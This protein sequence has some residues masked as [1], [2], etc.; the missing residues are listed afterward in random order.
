MSGRWPFPELSPAVHGGVDAVELAGL[1]V[2][3]A[4]VIDFSSNQSPL[5]VA[6]AARE[7]ANE[8]ELDSYPDRDARELVAALA[9]RHEVDPEWVVAGNGSTELIRLIAQLTLLP[10]DA[11]LS[12]APSFG[13]YEMGTLLARGRFLELPLELEAPSLGD[14]SGDLP[15]LPSRGGLS[16]QGG[17]AFDRIRFEAELHRAQPRLCWVCSPNN[18]TG[19]AV[20]PDDLETLL[21]GFPATLFVLD[22]AYCDLLPY[23][24]WSR[25]TLERGNLVVL[26]SM[27]KVW[28]L[29]GLRLGYAVADPSISGPLRAA[30][31]PWNVNACAQA[32]GLAAISQ[33]ERHV[34]AVELLREGRDELAAEIAALGFSVLRSSAGFFL[35][36]VDDPAAVR[37]S[38]LRH[39][40]LVRDCTSFGLPRHIRVSPKRADENDV[41][42]AAFREVA[43]NARPHPEADR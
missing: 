13:E 2:D 27:T 3:P 24:Q 20:P 21:H 5:G 42:V 41:L 31:P 39:R 35:I 36:E 1:G 14:T 28:G 12:L 34:R 33:D 26:R 10:G 7:A 22:E 8:A 9:A 30:S 11:A 19:A 18:P 25:P 38:L 32:A 43:E 17:F 23:P 29:A 15:D 37:L 40:C 6:P 16:S 4:S